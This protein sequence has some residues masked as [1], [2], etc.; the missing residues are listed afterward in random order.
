[1]EKL[2]F[3]KS[4]FYI[5]TEYP[6]RCNS[7]EKAR[8]YIHFRIGPEGTILRECGDEQFKCLKDGLVWNLIEFDCGKGLQVYEVNLQQ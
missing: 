4:Q 8:E 6:F 3:R 5:A 1:M 7:L 2:N